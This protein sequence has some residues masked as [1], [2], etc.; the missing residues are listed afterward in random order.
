MRSLTLS[1]IEG[2]AFARQTLVVFLIALAVLFAFPWSLSANNRFIAG[3]S[4]TT[5]LLFVSAIAAL[6][7]VGVV[8]LILKN[9]ASRLLTLGLP[10]SLTAAAFMLVLNDLAMGLVFNRHFLLSGNILILAGLLGAVAI[11]RP[12]GNWR[13]DQT[14]LCFVGAVT[15]IGFDQ[16]AS[17]IRAMLL[18]GTNDTF[19]WSLRAARLTGLPKLLDLPPGSVPGGLLFGL[20]YMQRKLSRDVPSYQFSPIPLGGPLTAA[21]VFGVATSTVMYMQFDAATGAGSPRRLSVMVPLNSLLYTVPAFCFLVGSAIK[22]SKLVSFS[23]CFASLLPIVA[24]VGQRHLVD[25]RAI[26]VAELNAKP[27]DWSTVPIQ[28]RPLMVDITTPDIEAHAQQRGFAN[29]FSFRYSQ[30]VYVR[31]VADNRFNGSDDF[32]EIT[33]GAHKPGK[34]FSAESGRPRSPAILHVYD[35]RDGKRTLLGTRIVERYL[36]PA[37]PPYLDFD[38]SWVL[39]RRRIL[40]ASE[41]DMIGRILDEIPS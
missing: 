40:E 11:M 23:V 3:I 31:G 34:R 39:D 4:I 6:P 14:T 10:V 41:A 37:F 9:F 28:G 18:P 22:R 35:V 25:W 17:L 26:E 13:R 20:G 8:G 30:G 2:K 33:L 16:Y 36:P 24:W 1:P 19:L 7:I 21:I 5:A 27:I 15:L 32:I 12:V 29:T 38:G